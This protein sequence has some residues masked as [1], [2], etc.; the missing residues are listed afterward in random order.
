[1]ARETGVVFKLFAG[2][3]VSVI[4]AVLV[5]GSLPSAAGEPPPPND[6]LADVAGVPITVEALVDAMQRRGGASGRVD[7]PDGRAALLDELVRAEAVY[8]AALRD[9][10]MEKPEIIRSIRLLIT[11]RYLEQNLA[12][13]LAALTVGDDEAAVY[14]NEHGQ[15]L[16]APRLVRGALIRIDVPAKA[17]AEKRAELHARAEA[18]RASAQALPAAQLLFGSV[19]VTYSD[20][21]ASRYRGGDMGLLRADKLDQRWDET[22]YRAIFAL[23]KP[24]DLSP[25]LTAPDGYY[26]VKLAEVR[27]ARVPPLA[28]VREQISHRILQQKQRKAEE[29]FYVALSARLKISVNRELLDNVPPPAARVPAEPPALPGK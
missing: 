28:E 20:D 13:I 19:A 26:I 15:E 2:F 1:M 22:V 7:T 27:E 23:E 5:A 10:Y 25:V 16:A 8:A 11:G 24:G 4:S 17:S 14:Y 12:P 6:V 18:A 3:C 21:Q 9:G 29:E